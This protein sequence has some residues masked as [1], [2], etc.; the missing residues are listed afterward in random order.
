MYIIG[1]LPSN[2]EEWKD[3]LV[4]YSK[5]ASSLGMVT[6]LNCSEQFN[7]HTDF[8]QASNDSTPWN[9]SLQWETI[10][11]VALAHMDSF[12]VLEILRSLDI[13]NGALSPDF[14]KSIMMSYLL[15]K[16]QR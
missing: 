14:Y 1:Y 6:C 5:S 9:S 11:K 8:Y 15:K 2:P 10:S 4:L 3:F 7:V 13:P 16:Q 12:K